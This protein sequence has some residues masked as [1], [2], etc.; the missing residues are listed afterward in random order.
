MSSD[1]DAHLTP[2]QRRML[3]ECGE[4]YCPLCG[5]LRGYSVPDVCCSSLCPEREDIEAALKREEPS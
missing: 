4:A 1:P 3:W 2:R 5:L